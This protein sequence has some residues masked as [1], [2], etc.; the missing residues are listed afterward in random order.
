MV[1]SIVHYPPFGE[2]GFLSQI[3]QII[4]GFIQEA[5]LDKI[6]NNIC[7]VIKSSIVEIIIII[8]KKAISCL[9][10]QWKVPLQGVK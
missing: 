9:F 10:Y 6:A 2:V 8:L 5:S 1:K 4:T 3:V 7:A